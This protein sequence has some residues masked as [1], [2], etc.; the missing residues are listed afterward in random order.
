FST[1]SPPP[2]GIGVDTTVQAPSA[3]TAAVRSSSA[4]VRPAARMARSKQTCHSSREAK[5][6]LP[7]SHG[8]RR[9]VG[10]PL[11]AVIRWADAHV[12]F[13]MFVEQTHDSGD[14]P[15][16]RWRD[17]LLADRTPGG[18]TACS[19]TLRVLNQSSGRSSQRLCCCS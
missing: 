6:V 9:D 14:Y 4:A 10:R 16:A 11:P 18:S 13:V 15:G 19:S 7:V 5:V 3:R 2:L 1:F 17:T 8:R 12:T